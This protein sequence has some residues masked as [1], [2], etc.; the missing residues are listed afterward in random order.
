MNMSIGQRS[1]SGPHDLASIRKY[2]KSHPAPWYLPNPDSS[3]PLS[4]LSPAPRSRLLLSHF[5]GT[6]P[7]SISSSL[8]TQ[9]IYDKLTGKSR[10][11]GFVTMST[12]EEV[13][14]AWQQFNGYDPI[15]SLRHELEA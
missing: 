12:V 5:S 6:I 15:S 11:F 2:F 8:S 14:A 9:V 1:E 10:G 3:L 7:I 13:K 4:F